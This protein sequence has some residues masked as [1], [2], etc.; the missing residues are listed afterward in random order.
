MEKRLTVKAKKIKSLY[1]KEFFSKNDLQSML[2]HLR[3]AENSEKPQLKKEIKSRLDT[4]GFPVTPKDDE[5]TDTE[6]EQIRKKVSQALSS[7]AWSNSI[8]NDIIHTLYHTFQQYA[9]PADFLLRLVEAHEPKDEKT[10]ES[11]FQGQKLRLRL[12]KMAASTLLDLPNKSMFRKNYHGLRCIKSYCS[13]HYC[14]KENLS[15]RELKFSILLHLD[16]HIFDN[17]TNASIDETR[18]NGKYGLL[19]VC[20]NL[21]K[22][23]FDDKTR[24]D[25]FFFAVAYQFSAE[26][27]IERLFEEY[28]INN[29]LACISDEADSGILPDGHGIHQKNYQD[30]VWLYY[31]NWQSND[32]ENLTPKET[33]EKIETALEELKGD[34]TYRSSHKTS[35]NTAYY[36]DILYDVIFHIEEEQILDFIKCH[37]D[38]SGKVQQTASAIQDAEF[39]KTKLSLDSGFTFLSSDII[40][41]ANGIIWES[42][43]KSDEFNSIAEQE[44]QRSRAFT[45]A[46]QKEQRNRAF[47]IA[48]QEEQRSKAFKR[49]VDDV[50]SI[51]IQSNCCSF[52][53]EK[54]E[55]EEYT[56]RMEHD[57]RRFCKMFYHAIRYM[58]NPQRNNVNPTRTDVLAHYHAYYNQKN[59]GKHKNFSEV[60]KDYTHRITGL[61]QYL[62]DANFIPMSE[63]NIIDMMCVLSSYYS[64][65]ISD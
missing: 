31:I 17:L 33:L 13:E 21:E 2:N 12:L 26:E 38:C 19:R 8:R 62:N 30:I 25:L 61:D 18:R 20:D 57:T 47:T 48:E 14:K 51:L 52:S 55:T 6:L 59:K 1:D 50:K 64:M 37:Y 11:I 56:K 24:E 43:L 46:E 54:G 3:Y 22:G 34:T 32:A 35:E 63:K 36:A 65:Q 15:L 28:Y 58:T 44:E 23:Y 53:C 45:I 4:L 41:E 39:M 40:R 27:C 29:L 7:Y 60:W 9:A 16:D 49:F 5:N 42:S 10:G